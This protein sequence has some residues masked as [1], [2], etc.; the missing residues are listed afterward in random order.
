METVASTAFEKTSERIKRSLI[1]LISR[2]KSFE[3]VSISDI[4]RE[5]GIHRSTF[6]AHFTD[7]FELLSNC[8]LDI[9]S[10]P[11]RVTD[12]Y[13]TA[14][15]YDRIL[16]LMKY[17]A[18]N[19]TAHNSFLLVI[20][21]DGKYPAY[22]SQFVK[23]L[24]AQIGQLVRLLGVGF[25]QRGIAIDENCG[26]FLGSALFGALLHWT[27]HGSLKDLDSYCASITG[28]VFSTLGL[29]PG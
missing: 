21:E 3:T 23:T 8:L 11:E 19:C 27:K 26:V 28:Y 2:E 29:P 22:Y 5:S 15:L 24:E 7:K 17:V 20:L 18:A 6:Y 1:D 14:G 4:C 13:A 12:Q 25:R 16:N 9:I 10:I